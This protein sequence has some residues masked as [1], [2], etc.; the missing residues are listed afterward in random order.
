L[1]TPPWHVVQLVAQLAPWHMAHD[2]VVAPP[3]P[4]S[5]VPWQDPQLASPEFAATAWN[6]ELVWSIQAVPCVAVVPHG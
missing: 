6:V 2:T 3:T 5:F 1:S 4:S